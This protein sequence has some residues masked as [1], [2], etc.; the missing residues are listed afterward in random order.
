MARRHSLMR[1]ASLVFLA[2][3]CTGIILLRPI[4][5]AAQSSRYAGGVRLESVTVDLSVLDALG[6]APTIPQMLRPSVRAPPTPL[7]RPAPPRARAVPLRPALPQA[8]L[9]TNAPGR[10]VL[11][12]PQRLQ[13]KPRAV[14]NGRATSHPTPRRVVAKPRKI[15]RSNASFP[16]P[17]TK[18]SP[19]PP[20]PMARL[21]S[22]TRTPKPAAT[23]VRAQPVAPVSRPETP[24]PPPTV[25]SRTKLPAPLKNLAPA[26]NA[27]P[28]VIA[29][30][31]Q[32]A[33]IAKRGGKETSNSLRDGRSY[34]LVFASN[35]A[36]LDSQA[37]ERLD[38]VATGMAGD[39]Q[40]RLQLMAYAGGESKTASESRRLSLS[41]ALAVRSY[42]IEKGVRSTRIDVRALGNKFK[43]G[44]PNRVDVVVTRR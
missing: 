44:P 30:P 15:A 12:P 18:P 25:A 16:P 36:K 10:I 7:A 8:R 17:K 20:R 4:L 22:R 33:S 26:R 14:P 37:T 13:A 23:R 11:K 39:N 32:S 43:A 40:L 27:R 19:P 29:K 35:A 9:I 31:T 5:S 21:A 2:V 28:K 6:P 3:I 1:A 41:R 24:P 34:S 38:E 42:L